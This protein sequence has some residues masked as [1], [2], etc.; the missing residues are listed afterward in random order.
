MDFIYLFFNNFE[1]LLPE[2][3]FIT[4]LIGLIF[5]SGFVI[6]NN[7][8]LTSYINKISLCVVGVMIVLILNTCFN[9]YN[10]IFIIKLII[11]LSVFCCLI[12]SENSILQTFEFSFLI[13]LSLVGFILLVMSFDL[14][15][16]YLAIEIQSISFYILGGLKKNSAFSTEAGLKYFILGALASGLFLLGCSLIYGTTGTI[17]FKDLAHVFVFFQSEFLLIVGSL[18]ILFAIFFKLS[19]A[20]FHI[21]SPD[22]YEGAPSIV[23]AF[24]SITPK[25]GILIILMKFLNEIFYES[26]SIIFWWETFGLFCAFLSIFIGSLTALQQTRIKRLLAYSAIGHVGYSLIGIFSGN[27]EGIQAVFFYLI[28]Y[29]ITNI[30]IWGSILSLH[31]IKFI[32]DLKNIYFINPFLCFILLISFFSLTGIPPLAGFLAKLSIFFSALESNLYLLVFFSVLLSVIS[33]FYY[34]RLIKIIS[35]EKQLI[36]GFNSITCIYSKLTSFIISV[37]FIS[38]FLFFVFPLPLS[39]IAYYLSL[40]CK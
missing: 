34:L 12:F 25:L 10:F 37:N 22:I 38:L 9:N 33:T 14:I 32:T 23:T 28:F 24:F 6:Y 8:I 3:Y 5:Y 13:L 15:L 16:L 7:Y 36:W 39:L 30:C 18:C 40:F 20:P 1:F 27:I 21:W 11:I 4:S 31:K 35:F 29:I 17:N 19:A 26:A 2:I